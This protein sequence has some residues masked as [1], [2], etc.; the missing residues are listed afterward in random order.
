MRQADT[1]L[2]KQN[3]ERLNQLQDAYD[4]TI[5][6]SEDRAI[7][8]DF[9][10][11][12]DVYRSLVTEILKMEG[13]KKDAIHKIVSEQ[14]RPAWRSGYALTQKMVETNKESSDRSST[15]IM[16]AV[17]VAKA[18]ML[19]AFV[20][21]LLIALVCGY[22]LLRAI[23]I[24]MQRLIAILDVM[25]T[26]DFSQRLHLE[27]SDEFADLASG[28]NRMTDE[29]TAL[30]GQAQKSSTQVSSSVTDDRRDLQATAGDCI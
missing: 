12:R 29:L 3:G 22:F 7:F 20:V 6:G 18:S 2:L 23:T 11:Q 8:E 21:A 30:V 15:S 27:R 24:P 14:L 26:G 25:R 19:F 1:A 28:F 10:R 17:A 13:S 16:D 4:K 5:H 9:K